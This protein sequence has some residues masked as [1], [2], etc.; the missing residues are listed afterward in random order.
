MVLGHGP[1]CICVS[2]K[3]TPGLPT[4]ELQV[5]DASQIA[6][7]PLDHFLMHRPGVCAKA[8]HCCNGKCD[9]WAYGEHSPVE[10]ANGLMIGDV[11]HH[12]KFSWDRRGL[13]E[14]KLSLSVHR[15]R[16]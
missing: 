16:E 4:G 11:M 8:H 2:L 1:V 14:C 15:H 3:N 5:M 13:L 12:S 10:C 9:V 7:T 6:E